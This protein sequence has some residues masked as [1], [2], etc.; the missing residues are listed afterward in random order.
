[1]VKKSAQKRKLSESIEVMENVEPK[2]TAVSIEKT[3]PTDSEQITG[4]EVARVTSLTRQND[5]DV[6]DE[7][8]NV[9]TKK[10]KKKK[11]HRLSLTKTTDF[12][13]KLRKRGVLYLSRIPPRMNPTKVKALLS[14]YG[15][16]VTRVYLVEED[17]TVRKRRKRETGSR[18][19]GKRYVEG[20]VEMEDRKI[21]KRIAQS[22]NTTAITNHKRSV[23]YGDLW[24]M[25]FLSKFQW[26]H[27]TEKVAYERRMRE[28]KIRIEMLQA[29]KEN[30]AYTELVETGKKLDRIEKRRR[31]RGDPDVASKSSDY[32]F[33]QTKPLQDGTDGAAK[34]AVLQSLV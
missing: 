30:A 23:H 4:D 10:I 15:C 33:H 20:W 21:A 5:K 7:E 25:K 17:P 24:N 29:R 31:K 19:S 28:Q 16:E 8:D 18:Q 12:N 14:D 26:S 32:R 22:L 2:D 13:E 1:M 27:L 6:S 34:S 9:V 11:V 3:E